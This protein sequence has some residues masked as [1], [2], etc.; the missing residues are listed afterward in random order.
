MGE[1]RSSQDVSPSTSRSSAVGPLQPYTAGGPQA[2]FSYGAVG[3]A[4]NARSVKAFVNGTLVD[5][6][7]MDYF[8]DLK[9]TV[10]ISTSLLTP[11]SFQVR[12]EN[13]SLI[14]TDR[15][16]VS[17]FEINYPRQFNFNNLPF[18]EFTWPAK[19]SPSLLEISNFKSGG[20]TPLL[21]D[22]TNKIK[23]TAQV[24]ER[25]VQV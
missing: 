22:L 8:N 4:Q 23:Y 15:Y 14:G 16:V 21:I 20:Q 19:G 5:E 10:N 7:V 13:G 1:F 18:F 11:A 25:E 24:A 2:T 12:W 6:S 9:R 3:N 17:Y